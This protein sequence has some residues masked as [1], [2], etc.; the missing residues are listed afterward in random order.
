MIQ[1]VCII[2]KGSLL[3]RMVLV[4][5]SRSVVRRSAGPDDHSFLHR[6]GEAGKHIAV[7]SYWIWR[8]Q[9]WR[10]CQK[11]KVLVLT[12]LKSPIRFLSSAARSS[13]STGGAWCLDCTIRKRGT[14]VNEV[15]TSDSGRN[16]KELFQSTIGSRKKCTLEINTVADSRPSFRKEST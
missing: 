7:V 9:I 16:H 13:I 8:L 4:C 3:R 12:L 11:V 15:E 5:Y 10:Y 14:W 6:G 2:N 1:Q